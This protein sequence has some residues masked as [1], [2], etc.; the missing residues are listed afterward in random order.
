M[1]AERASG[2]ALSLTQGPDLHQVRITFSQIPIKRAALCQKC[3]SRMEKWGLLGSLARCF[4]HWSR[5][6]Y[7]RGTCAR[8]CVHMC[9]EGESHNQPYSYASSLH[10]DPDV[11]PHVRRVSAG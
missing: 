11:S 9:G 6:A 4:F 7:S 10:L 3:C 1:G 2:R 8:L 5:D